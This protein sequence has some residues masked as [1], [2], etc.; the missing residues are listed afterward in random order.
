M[1]TIAE[2][3]ARRERLI[4]EAARQRRNVAAR[5]VSLR[6]PASVVA[7]GL[8]VID[9]LRQ[10]PLVIGAAVAAVVVVRPRRALSLAARG[11]FLWRALRTI[12]GFLAEVRV[13][14]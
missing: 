7:S 11:V 12:R 10:H 14:S 1:K 2:I 4:A 3:R 6:G 13:S 8:N 9:W 5:Y